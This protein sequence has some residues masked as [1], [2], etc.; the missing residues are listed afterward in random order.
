MAVV[1][2]FSFNFSFVEEILVRVWSNGGERAF[3]RALRAR[4]R[5]CER[6]RNMVVEMDRNFICI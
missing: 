4:A 5:V 1:Q 2:N 6:E 3:V